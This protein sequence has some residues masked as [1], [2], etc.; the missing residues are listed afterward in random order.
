MNKE[1][2]SLLEILS[3]AEKQY[4]ISFT[5]ANKVIEAIQLPSYNNDLTLDETIDYLIENTP[6]K[7]T[8]LTKKN[9]LISKK[10]QGNY[11]CGYL[12]DPV[13]K[14]FIEDASITI[15]NNQTISN[16]AGFFKFENIAKNQLVQISHLSYPTIF[17]NS[18]DLLSKG[19]CLT[20]LVSQKTE[21]LNEVILH[22]YLTSGITISTNNTIA[23]DVL[24]SG[25][26][27]GLIEPDILQ[28]IQAIPGIS[29]INESISN[30]NIRGGSNDQNLLLW[31]G[32][33]MY[34]SGHFF[35]LISA[36]NPYLTDKVTLTKNGTSSQYNDGVSGTINIE[37]INEISEKP[38]GG[39]GFNLLSADGYAHIPISEKVGFQFTGRRAITDL[40]NTPTFE[41]YFKKTFQDSKVT[42]ST[43]TENIKTNSTF[44][45]SDYS[46]KILYDLNKNHKLRLS[47]FNVDNKFHFNESKQSET[48]SD[49]K[50]SELEQSNIA[51]G[52]NI[53][54]IWSSKFK[55]VFHTYYTKYNVHA[56][57]FSLLNNQRLIQVNEVLETGIKLNTFYQINKNLQFLNGY[58]FYELGITNSEDVNIPLFIRTIKN[59]IR[60]H[61]LYSEINFISNNKKTFINSGFRLNYVEK[62]KIF[63]AEPRIQALYKINANI[64]V[65]IAGE[66][67]SQNATQIIDLQ[68]DFLGVE[69]SRWTLADENIIPIIKSKQASLGIN[70]KKN[71]FFIDLEGFYKYVNG[72]T[73]ANQGFQNQNQFIKT[74]GSYT[75]KGLEFIINKNT[76][77]FSTWVGY[78]YN[79]NDYE[80]T[81]LTPTIFPNN[82]DIRHS[83]SFGNTY[84]YK[85][86]DFAL[87]L[88]WRTGKPHTSPLNNNAISTNGISNSINY[89]DPN[90]E[91]LSNYFRAD[92]SSTYKF[93][94]NE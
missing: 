70:Y 53:T 29:S 88:L 22:N 81:E 60:N 44:N 6:L 13:L 27:P 56:E 24:N 30:I 46:F 7:F 5:Y 84:T 55:T 4:N 50:T 62:F 12:F 68:E 58:H 89:N 47:Y 17:I 72:I 66:F 87:G 74:T 9:I 21:L 1:N 38:F 2:S 16:N 67:K 83:I 61:A 20:I 11:I 45:F 37:T 18:N 41:Q 91:R 10:K 19:T 76:A 94:L 15:L 77:T 90:S 39:A 26:L 78:T 49:S 86:I 3:I 73:T 42:A 40:I 48:I 64:S 80:F 65:K 92:F 23:I 33:K 31:D 93:K 36:F 32:I 59:V 35:G 79:K 34:H 43:I 14:I 52:L 69:K 51:I 63:I 57:N 54:D 75:V 85:K 25:I 28:K 71:N 82:L 8:Y